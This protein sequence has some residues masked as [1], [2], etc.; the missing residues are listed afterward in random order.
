VPKSK[1][2]LAVVHQRLCTAYG[3]LPYSRLWNAAIQGRIP[4]E[5]VGARWAVDETDI[6]RVAET[7]G[8]NAPATA[9]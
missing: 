5:R 4:A 7:L 1:L 9:A 3:P 2:V 6:S 8:L